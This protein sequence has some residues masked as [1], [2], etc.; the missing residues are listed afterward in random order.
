M[1]PPLIFLPCKPKT[2]V[3]IWKAPSLESFPLV[4]LLMRLSESLFLLTQIACYVTAMHVLVVQ[5]QK[6]FYDLRLI[7]KMIFFLV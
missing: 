7:T 2:F 4:L 6:L 1:V 3:R 5:K